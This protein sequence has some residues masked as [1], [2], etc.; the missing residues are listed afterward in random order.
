MKHIAT[1]LYTVYLLGVFAYGQGLGPADAQF[2]DRH[3]IDSINLQSLSVAVNFRVIN[4]AGAIPFSYSLAGESSCAPIYYHTGNIAGCG[5][6]VV[7]GPINTFNSTSPNGA[8]N[9]INAANGWE[10]SATTVFNSTCTQDGN[11]QTKYSGLYLVAPDFTTYY[12][13]AADYVIAD[14]A[15]SD[16]SKGL[17]DF[18][19]MGGILV[20]IANTM[21]GSVTLPNGLVTPIVLN[22]LPGGSVSTLTDPFG[23]TITHSYGPDQY[24][25]TLGNST[26][27]VQPDQETTVGEIDTWEDT[28]GTKQPMSNVK[29]AM[30]FKTNFSCSTYPDEAISAWAVTELEYPDGNNVY[31][32]YE[33]SG[34]GNVTGRVNQ[35]ILR[36][37]GTIGYTYGSTLCPSLLPSSLSRTTQDGLTTYALGFF[38]SQSGKYGTTTTVIDPG[39]NKTVYTFMGTYSSGIPIV[40]IPLTLTQVQKYQNTG[41]VASPV[42]TLLSTILYCYNGNT[43]NCATTQAAYPITQKDVY[44]TIAG[45]ST[46]SRVSETFD[47]YGNRTSVA[48]YDFGAS[49]FTTKTTTTYGSWTGSLPCP[50]VGS[51]INN[52]PCDVV[53]TDNASHTLAESRLTYNSQGFPTQT[54]RWTGSAWLT[55]SATPNTNGTVARSTAGNGQVTN[56]SYAATGS[57]GCN[58]LLLTGTSTT[59][60][61]VV[62]TTGTTWDCNTSLVLMSTDANSNPTHYT[63]DAMLRPTSTTDPL[64]FAVNDSYTA[65]TA[66]ASWSMT[67]ASTSSTTTVDGLGRP[68]LNQTT[69]GS[70]YNTTSNSYQFVGPNWTSKPTYPCL[71]QSLGQPCSAG[72]TDTLDPLGRPITIVGSAGNTSTYNYTQNDLQ[73]TLSPAPTGEHNKVSQTEYDGLGRVKST[74]GILTSGGTSCGQVMGGSGIVTTNTYSFNTGS[75]TVVSTRGSQSRTTISDALGRV[76]SSTT[77]EGG[78]TTYIYDSYPPGTCGGWTSQPGRPNAHDLR[79]R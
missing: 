78:T 44:T 18:T 61:G 54:Q 31:F 55:S 9:G 26:F 58:S 49:S 69:A 6:S 32:S 4:K 17:T 16:C 20:T 76:T 67:G 73:I 71:Q 12:L 28:S 63:Y 77:P 36:T 52:L 10:L 43:A 50:S 56:Y 40:G 2:Y 45:M 74:C 51:N 42:Y 29:A 11:Q 38:T 59:V 27:T 33:P 15:P 41:T 79:R 72:D 3:Q 19:T 30:T 60:N 1:M 48:A 35:I 21:A 13:P 53:T 57:G 8:L 34:S 22:Q 64:T 46:S 75:S 62:L 14:P 24:T 5:I 47:S 7:K 68:I 65:T 39:K 23:N 25:D 66:T 70:Q 37:G